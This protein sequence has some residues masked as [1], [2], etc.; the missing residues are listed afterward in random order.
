VTDDLRAVTGEG[1]D[2]VTADFGLTMR[3]P[4]DR[5]NFDPIEAVVGTLAYISPETNFKDQSPRYLFPAGIGCS[6]NTAC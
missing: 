4:A 3:L 6:C 5:R 2:L 1:E